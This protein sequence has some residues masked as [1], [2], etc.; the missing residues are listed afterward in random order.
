[1]EQIAEVPHA[2]ASRPAQNRPS[3]SRGVVGKQAHHGRTST[4]SESLLHPCDSWSSKKICCGHWKASRIGGPIEVEAFCF[5]VPP[6]NDAIAFCG[7]A[8]IL[9]GIP[10]SLSWGQVKL[11]TKRLNIDAF[12]RQ[13]CAWLRGTRISRHDLIKYVAN[14]KGRTYY[15]P[16]RKSE[17]QNEKFNLLLGVEHHGFAGIGIAFNGLNLV[18]HEIASIDLFMVN[19]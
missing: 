13:P 9:P 7:G 16:T 15:D 12:L 17:P 2:R 8:D 10:V 5:E 18:H 14:T 6:D 1:V 11:A 19:N 4:A 3:A